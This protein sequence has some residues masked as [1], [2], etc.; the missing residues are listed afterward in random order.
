ME[1][2]VRFIKNKEARKS[3]NLIRRDFQEDKTLKNH[4]K[5]YLAMCG[6]I[7]VF[8]QKPTVYQ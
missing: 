1:M 8:R 5:S 3:E 4:S 2:N 7:L 6:C